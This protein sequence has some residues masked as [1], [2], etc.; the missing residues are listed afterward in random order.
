MRYSSRRVLAQYI[1]QHDADCG[2]QTDALIKDD[3]YC[4]KMLFGIIYRNHLS[5]HKL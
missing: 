4:L 5:K 3:F 2:E 1:N